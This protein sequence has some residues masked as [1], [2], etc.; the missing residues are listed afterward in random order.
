MW[1]AGSSYGNV[2]THLRKPVC[3]DHDR[4]IAFITE[5]NDSDIFLSEYND[6]GINS[7]LLGDD[8]VQLHQPVNDSA[9]CKNGSFREICRVS[10]DRIW[11]RNQQV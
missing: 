6:F 4:N 1:S 10:Y 8:F 9:E 2:M 3:W 7:G 11:P 5:I